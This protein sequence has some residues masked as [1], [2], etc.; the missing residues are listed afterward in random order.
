MEVV[1]PPRRIVSLCP[2]LTETLF[3]LGLR[4]EVVGRT[5]YCVYPAEQIGRLPAVGGPKKVDIAAVLGLQPDVV[6]AAKEENRR[7]DVE[8]IAARAAVYVVDVTNFERALDAIGDL[9]TLVD[10][11]EEA[12]ALIGEISARFERLR[13]DKPRRV[14]YLIWRKPYMA[15]GQ[16]TYIHS[17][18]E[19]CGWQNACA[20][21]PGRYPRVDL[22][23]LQAL[24]PELILL[25]SEPFSFEE[26]HAAELAP[27]LPTTKIRRVD[28]EMFGWYGARMLAAAKYLQQLVRDLADFG[29]G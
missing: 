8:A 13:R 25:S 7:Q 9:G 15:V 4:A 1:F 16:G 6:I 22:D 24:A 19:R 2:S 14:A 10:R 27:H 29:G 23:G 11:E 28:G 5:T 17:L 18:L 12:E 20:E 26:K 21:L 3:A